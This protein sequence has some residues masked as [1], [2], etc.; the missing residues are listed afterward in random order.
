VPGAAISSGE[1]LPR[2]NER[3]NIW[4][5]ILEKI[6]NAEKEHQ[7]FESPVRPVELLKLKAHNEKQSGEDDESHE[8]ERSATPR[9]D[10]EK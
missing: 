2:Y 3:G 8:L 9:I 4:A 10:D 5:K 1:D 7:N 6:C